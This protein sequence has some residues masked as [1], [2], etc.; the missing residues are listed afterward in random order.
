MLIILNLKANGVLSPQKFKFIDSPGGAAFHF[1]TETLSKMSA[2]KEDGT[3]SPLGRIMLDF[4]VDPFAAFCLANI[5]QEN[6]TIQ[7]DVVTIV[8]ILSAE[9]FFLSLGREKNQ[10][11]GDNRKRFVV[12]NS[13][14]LTKLNIFYKYCEAKN[15]KEFCQIFGLRKKTLENCLMIR[16]QL[17]EILQRIK[18]R[19][20][21][22]ETPEHRQPFTTSKNIPILKALENVK[23]NYSFD[24]DKIIRILQ[25]SFFTKIAQL[26]H[27]GEYII[28]HVNLR[29]KI[30]PE[31]V[32][33]AQ[34]VKPK[35]IVFN[36]IINTTK[37]YVSN[38]SEVL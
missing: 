2:I 8:A 19:I 31:S 26:D 6:E 5:I 38:A 15:K 4:P 36:T 12:A 3:I 13:D 24:K 16:E 10:K 33:F 25:R 29:V 22:S 1:A 32:I 14:H 23:I 28:N 37:L 30:H 35:K 17:Y 27:H 7:N 9:N 20:E 34:R 21:R 18:A 11:E